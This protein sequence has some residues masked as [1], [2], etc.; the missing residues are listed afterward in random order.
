LFFSFQTSGQ[1]LQKAQAYLDRSDYRRAVPLYEIIRDEAKQNHDIDLQVTAQNGLADCYLDLGATYKAMTI[2]KQNIF[3]LNKSTNKNYLLLG[4]THQLL[5]ICY[6]K[7]YLIEDYLTECNAF[8][9][10]YKKA[11]PDKEIYKALYYAFVGRYYNM[12]YIIDKAFLY[13]N[14][15]IEIYHKNNKEKEVDPY[16]FYN[17]HL[18]TLRNNG[19]SHIKT[20]RFRDSVSYFINKRFPYD[21]LEKAR[22]LISLAAP[23]LDRVERII[24]KDSSEVI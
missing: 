4:K 13:T 15:A 16:I 12:R 24:A 23:N 8:Y 11:A 3:L 21:N 1:S 22:L 19:T 20:I 10:Y 14:S 5:A 18:F 6:D 17:A 2:L 9:S 7:L